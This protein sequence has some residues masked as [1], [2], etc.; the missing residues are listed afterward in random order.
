MRLDSSNISPDGKRVSTIRVDRIG[1][2]GQ[3]ELWWVAEAFED[4]TTKPEGMF[5]DKVKAVELA[6]ELAG[7]WSV[8]VAVSAAD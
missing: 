8:Q 4:G 2:T 3:Q 7:K 1:S 5:T 6:T